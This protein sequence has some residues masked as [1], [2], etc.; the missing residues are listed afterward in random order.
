MREGDPKPVCYLKAGLITGP[1]KVSLYFTNST[2]VDKFFI[3]FPTLYLL[4][5]R[6]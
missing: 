2:P 6:I 1:N 5:I 3:D 4:N